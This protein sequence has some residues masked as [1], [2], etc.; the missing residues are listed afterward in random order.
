MNR[1]LPLVAVL[2]CTGI[3]ASAQSIDDLNIQI[4]G[5]ATQGFAYTSQNNIFTMNSSD[6]SAE[7]TDIVLNLTAQPIPK[8]RIGAQARYFVLGNYGNAITI[9][10]ASA[11]Y[12]FSDRLGVRFG[13]VKT[14]WGLFNEVQDIDP[15][16]MFALLPESIYPVDNRTAYL[17]HYGGVLYGTLDLER[18]GKF[19]YRAFGGEGDYPAN[20]GYFIDQKEAGYDLP[21]DI[22]GALFGGAIRWRTPLHGLMIGASALSDRSWTA[23]ET[24]T[25][26][27]GVFNGTYTLPANT[28]PNYFAM[29]ERNKLMV[30]AE[31]ERSWGDEMNAFADAPEASYSQRN[32]DRGEY[33]MATYKLTPKLTVGAYNSQNSDHQ[34]DLGPGRYSKD[35]TFSGR[36]DFSQFLYAKGEEHFIEGTGLGYDTTLNTNLQPNTKLTALK[37]GVSF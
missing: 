34:A 8:L 17:S 15:A 20:S 13:K 30:A 5:Y 22:S 18:A 28:Q 24:F 12:R 7:W 14:P 33:V 6:G 26:E 10:W 35:W 3:P 1:W 23:V 37:I 36:Y 19:E 29:Y 27:S 25:G 21:N 11:D 2:A 32:D 9:D 16:Y 4:H 31:Y